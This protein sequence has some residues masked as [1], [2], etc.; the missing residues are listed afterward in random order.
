MFYLRRH[1]TQMF[2]E[3]ELRAFLSHHAEVY[4]VMTDDDYEAVSRT[5]PIPL[6][7]I[8]RAPR[9]EAQ[10]DDFL[11]RS[12]LPS[13]LLVR[14]IGSDPISHFSL[15]IEADFAPKSAQDDNRR[16][17]RRPGPGGTSNGKACADSAF[18][19]HD[20]K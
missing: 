3:E 7:V 17:L 4:L 13:L 6:R 16:F 10:L 8:A 15:I 19:G 12:E 20:R 5:V 1:V 18:R 14:K 9:F 11:N 2:G